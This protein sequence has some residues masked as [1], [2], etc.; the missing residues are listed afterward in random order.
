MKENIAKW[1]KEGQGEKVQIYDQSKSDSLLQF[2][3]NNKKMA[4]FMKCQ[5]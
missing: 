4:T 2:G 1:I 3:M 5:T